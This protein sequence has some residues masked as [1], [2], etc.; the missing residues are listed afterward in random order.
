MG[1]PFLNRMSVNRERTSMI[2]CYDDQTCEWCELDDAGDVQA[3]H[4]LSDHWI[5]LGQ[6]V[7]HVL[8]IGTGQVAAITKEKT[9]RWIHVFQKE[10]EHIRVI[11][12]LSLKLPFPVMQLA[13]QDG[14]LQLLFAVRHRSGTVQIGLYD[15]VQEKAEWVT[16][17]LDNLQFVFWAKTEREIGV[18]VGGAGRVYFYGKANGSSREIPY[19]EYAYPVMD[20]QGDRIAVCIPMEDGFCP[21]WMSVQERV[22]HGSLEHSEPFSELIRIQLDVDQQHILCEGILRGKWQYIQYTLDGEK[23]FELCDYPGTLTQ[24]VHSRDKQNLIG[25]YESITTAPVPA[26]CRI[27]ESFGHITPLSVKHGDGPISNLVKQP[28]TKYKHMRYGNAFIPYMDIHPEGKEQAVIYLHGGPHNCLLDSYSPVIARLYEAGVRVIGLN[29]PG[30]SGFGSDYKQRIQDDWGGVDA[31][32]I[33]L[34]REQVLGSY[35]AVS[36]Y[37]VSYGAYLALL[38]AGRKP[39]LW[40]NVVACAPF[41]D[42]SSLYAGGGA[43]LRSFLQTEIGE[44]LQDKSALRDRSPLTYAS[45]LCEVDLQL[46][47]GRNDQLCPVEQTEHLYREILKR[48]EPVEA[49]GRQLEMHIIDDLQHEVYAERIWAARAVHFLT[50]NRVIQPEQAT[51]LR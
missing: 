36:L 51:K 29:Y 5:G 39:E 27:S 10:R 50:Q 37:G 6:T 9:E 22:V 49:K 42:L 8:F 41:T 19:Q 15:P 46:V 21:G 4:C 23:T 34:I 47:H 25:K 44:L 18:N 40:S 28:E 7:Q 17:E 26:K 14:Q 20:K 31:D 1:D 48:K 12:T 45:A 38:A 43:K 3:K 24:A 2:L 13:W 30:S 35:S 11:Q 16:P 32:V 33:R